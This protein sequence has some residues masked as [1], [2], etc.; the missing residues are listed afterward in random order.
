MSTTTFMLLTLP[1]PTV[2]LGPEWAVELNAALT[3][4]DEHDHTS[5]KGK[6]ITTAALNIDA[7]V[8]FNLSALNDV[9]AVRLQD[10]DNT[11]T[12]AANSP[13]IYVKSGD[14]WY[15]NSSGVPV[16]ITSGGSIVAPGVTSVN[17]FVS[18]PI[19]AID[20][21]IGAGDLYVIVPVDTSA[22]ARNITLPLAANVSN[23][24]L[25]IIK[26]ATGSSEINALTVSTQGGDLIDGVTS[27]VLESAYGSIFV[28]SDGV[29]NWLIV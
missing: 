2:T 18:N 15:T 22:G 7:D 23:G 8:P 14:F 12:G 10:L 29:S 13:S 28:Y 17:K 20:I 19:T 27:Q 25:F 9:H 6:R 1:V 21:T 4:V 5:N 16:Q 11:L 26:D 3:K 24:R